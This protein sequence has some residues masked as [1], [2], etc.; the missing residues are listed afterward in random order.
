MDKQKTDIRQLH[1]V[2]VLPIQLVSSGHAECDFQH[3]YVDIDT[4]FD[5]P[6]G[7]TRSLGDAR[8]TFDEILRL[9][10][11]SY[12][13]DPFTRKVLYEYDETKANAI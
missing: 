6:T 9:C 5:G 3:F 12:Y 4:E 7:N 11:A 8:Y 13:K 2:L 1:W 10:L